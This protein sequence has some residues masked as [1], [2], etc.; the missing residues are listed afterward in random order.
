M[1]IAKNYLDKEELSGLNNIVE[2]Y[3]G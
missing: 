2:Q 3:F 1:V